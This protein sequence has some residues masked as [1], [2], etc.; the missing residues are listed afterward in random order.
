MENQGLSNHRLSDNDDI[1]Y[2]PN[3]IT[4]SQYPDAPKFEYLGPFSG[5]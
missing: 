3:F 5:K 4:V 2:I 1:F